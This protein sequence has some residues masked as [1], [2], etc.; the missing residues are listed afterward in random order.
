MT[1]EDKELLLKDLSGRLPYGVKV[2]TSL[3]PICTIFSKP[4]IYSTVVI[5]GAGEKVCNISDIKPY[6]FPL[7]SIT[8]ELWR[9]FIKTA[10]YEMRE[11]DCGRHT[12]IYYYDL[13]GHE[14]TLYPNY[15]AI[16]WLNSHHFDYRALIEK[17]LAIDATGSKIY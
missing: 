7:S 3:K 13:V 16:D 2:H 1:Q 6:L 10:G 17:G 15:D 14:K 4:S 5:D 11:E 12:E 8:E 9:D